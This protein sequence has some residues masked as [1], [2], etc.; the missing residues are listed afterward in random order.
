[1]RMER[2]VDAEHEGLCRP[3][4]VIQIFILMALGTMQVISEEVFPDQ[5]GFAQSLPLTPSNQQF[6]NIQSHL[7]AAR[8]VLMC[9]STHWGAGVGRLDMGIVVPST[10]IRDLHAQNQLPSTSSFL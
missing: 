6:S 8:Q 7:P 5:T 3:Y 10:L 1:M 2:W 9:M 4:S